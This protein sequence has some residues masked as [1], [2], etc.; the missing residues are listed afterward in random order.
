MSDVG[1]RMS[2]VGCRRS[3]VGSDTPSRISQIDTKYDYVTNTTG[4]KSE[5]LASTYVLRPYVVECP[6][7]GS[8]RSGRVGSKLSR[9]WYNE[10]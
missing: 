3:E 8:G 1:G 4:C 9:S 7:F 5:D 10:E 2:D 6:N